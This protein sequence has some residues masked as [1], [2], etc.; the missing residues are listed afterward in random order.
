MRTANPYSNFKSAICWPDDE[1]DEDDYQDEREPWR[2]PYVRGCEKDAG[3]VQFKSLA[4]VTAQAVDRINHCQNISPTS[5]SPIETIV[6][7]AVLMF[8]ERAGVPLKLC[9]M[10]DLRTA[11][12]A[13][14]LV[15]QFAWS[16][17]RSDWA[18]MNPRRAGILLIECDGKDWHSS[19]EQKAHDTKKDLAALD[20]GYLT[21]R[22]SGSQIHKDAD[23]CAQKIFDAV[24]G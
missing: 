23:G 5:D 12:D 1:I 19:E 15:P 4:E 22:F 2:Q 10:I 16:Y 6:G 8:F 13:L 20:C 11:P 14:L 9:K 17:Y 24:Y 18:I 3:D 21:L 7:A